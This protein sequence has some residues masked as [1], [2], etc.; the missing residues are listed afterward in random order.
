MESIQIKADFLRSRMY[1]LK[2]WVGGFDLFKVY[3]YF[4]CSVLCSDFS[5]EIWFGGSMKFLVGDCCLGVWLFISVL[6][7]V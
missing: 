6:S 3:F 2:F 5:I 7:F 4:H 1:L